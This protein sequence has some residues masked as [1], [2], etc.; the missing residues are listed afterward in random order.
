MSMTA[1]K[2]ILV[3]EDGQKNAEFAMSDL[4]GNNLAKL[5]GKVCHM[6]GRLQAKEV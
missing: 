6:G 3:V 2:H 4:A 1:V 5:P